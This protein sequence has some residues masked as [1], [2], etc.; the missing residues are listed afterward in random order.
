[1][2]WADL[3]GVHLNG[4]NISGTG[5]RA[6]LAP[7]SAKGY[8]NGINLTRARLTGAEFGGAMAK[9]TLLPL[10]LLIGADFRDT[11][12]SGAVLYGSDM[13]WASFENSILTDSDFSGSNLQ[14]VIF[15]PRSGTLPK[16]ASIASAHN[17][18]KMTFRESPHQL[19]ELRRAFYQA[20][21]TDQ[22]KRLRV[23]SDWVCRGQAA[24]V[25]CFGSCRPRGSLASLRGRRWAAA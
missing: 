10:S 21:L 8:S 11:D 9:E 4:A 24:P 7:R 16:I 20:D 6:E 25:F 17:L 22:A 5:V 14:G 19:S 2:A 18:E 15:E 23:L 3:T 1:M 12:L 13:R